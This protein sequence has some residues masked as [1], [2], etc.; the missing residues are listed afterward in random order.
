[1]IAVLVGR[2]GAGKSHLARLLGTCGWGI[3]FKQAYLE[4]L[5]RT[6]ADQGDWVTWYRNRYKSA[7]PYE[8]MNE[9]LTVGLLTNKAGP[10]VLDSIHNLEEWRAIKDR[11]DSAVLVSVVAPHE[12]RSKRNS[13]GDAR[14]DI[15]R[16][17]YWHEGNFGECL[18][19]DVEWTFQGTVPDEAQVSN[20]YM[21]TRWLSS[22]DP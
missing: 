15:N 22:R 8:V 4:Q 3:R 9:L 18:M 1:M 11:E 21:F 7:G 19:A 6:S 5:H 17:H 12:V 16:V 2:H 10:M 14:L 20:I 13:P